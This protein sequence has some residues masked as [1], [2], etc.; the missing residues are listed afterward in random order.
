[1]TMTTARS[2]I[3]AS[4]TTPVRKRRRN[5]R[6][7]RVPVRP[8]SSDLRGRLVSVKMP[9]MQCSPSLLARGRSVAPSINLSSP[10][11][12]ER[13]VVTR[14]VARAR[15]PPQTSTPGATGFP[16]VVGPDREK[17][18]R[19]QGACCRLLPRSLGPRSEHIR[20]P[21]APD[22]YTTSVDVRP[23]SAPLRDRASRLHPACRTRRRALREAAG[24]VT[25]T[26][27][28]SAILM[29]CLTTGYPRLY[30]DRTIE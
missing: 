21:L 26:P 6:P 9:Q 7:I 14:E 24:P 23:A 19:A 27:R 11:V 8:T 18:H 4:S 13:A 15:V 10:A 25:T 2:P 20:R 22:P 30:N 1:M 3:T 29:R 28:A 5:A 17:Q 16:E 12:R